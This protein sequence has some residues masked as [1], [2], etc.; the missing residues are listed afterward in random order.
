[1]ATS[2]ITGSITYPIVTDG[3]SSSVLLGSP[4]VGA[5]SS[6][7]LTV[8]YAE[9]GAQTLSVPTASP[10]SLPMS[11]VS[12]GSV[13]YVGASAPVDVILNGGAERIAIG[14]GG[15]V[16]LTKCNITEATVQ[17]TSSQAV[18]TFI[19]LGD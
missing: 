8:T 1:M 6:T 10:T 2:T 19:V 12:S 7:G 4:A 16:L 5:S 3:A 18:V 15:F 13:F 11:T 9:G 17:A 14:A